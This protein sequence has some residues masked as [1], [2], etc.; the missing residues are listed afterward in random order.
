[1]ISVPPWPSLDE[2]KDDARLAGVYKGRKPSI[3]VAKIE[4]QGFRLGPDRDR[5]EAEDRQGV[6]VSCGGATCLG[7]F[8]GIFLPSPSVRA[9]YNF[10]APSRGSA[11]DAGRSSTVACH[12]CTVES[13]G[14]PPFV[15]STSHCTVPA[16]H[17]KGKPHRGGTRRG[18]RN[19]GRPGIGGAGGRPSP[20]VARHRDQV[21]SSKHR[22]STASPDG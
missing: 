20:L 22:Y 4:A 2:T 18:F 17:P 13:G 15:R 3:D 1:V 7:E 14:S 6:G 11:E 9:R 12:R 16:S 8:A 21:Q 5:A 10:P 19:I